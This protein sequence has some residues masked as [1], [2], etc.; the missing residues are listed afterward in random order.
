MQFW[1]F[2]D[3]EM[4][5]LRIG[6]QVDVVERA[7]EAGSRS[8]V[9][10]IALRKIDNASYVRRHRERLCT[11]KRHHEC[12]WNAFV[13]QI[14]GHLHGGVGAERMTNEDDWTFLPGFEIG[15]GSIGDW[16]SVRLAVRRRIH[17]IFLELLGQSVHA[18]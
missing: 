2:V 3:I 14:I 11:V 8:H 13:A 6:A 15:C 9:S 18:G 5:N 4:A 10:V 1:R 12:H 7:V 17:A 16:L